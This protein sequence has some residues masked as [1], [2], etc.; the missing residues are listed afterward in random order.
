M[1]FSFIQASKDDI[2]ELVRLRIAFLIENFGS[3]SEYE[4]AQIEKQLPDYF[5]RKLGSELIAFVAKLGNEIA[6][7]VYLHMIEMPSSPA[8]LTGFYGEV[9]SVYTLKEYRGRGL[10][11]TL[12]KML[13]EYGKSHNLSRIDLSA[14]KAG[15]PV[16]K[17]AGF[18]EKQGHYTEMR[19][20]LMG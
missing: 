3:V 6:A 17:K 4:K 5:N 1:D 18:S 20:N 9:H 13:V 11:F 14:T 12:M 15:Y 7:V 8:V 19:L 10:C 16:Y 2:P